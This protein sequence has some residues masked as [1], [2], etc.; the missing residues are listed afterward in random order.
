M[1][2]INFL[3]LEV[4]QGYRRPGHSLERLEQFRLC[5]HL[6]WPR[7]TMAFD[8]IAIRTV[9]ANRSFLPLPWDRRWRVATSRWWNSEHRQWGDTSG[10]S[11]ARTRGCRC[12]SDE[13]PPRWS[14]LCVT[15]KRKYIPWRSSVSRTSR[16]V[17]GLFLVAESRGKRDVWT[18]SMTTSDRVYLTRGNSNLNTRV[19][20]K[21]NL[22][23]LFYYLL[24]SKHM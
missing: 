17:R 2:L 4:Y 10:G 24:I 18:P 1:R 14:R 15:V 9:R 11:E 7:P 12:R 5:T 23:S 3:R 8:R 20:D 13:D 16:S 6:T 22:F 21:A 19:L